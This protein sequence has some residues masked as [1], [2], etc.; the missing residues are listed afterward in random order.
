ME[1]KFEIPA[2]SF[3]SALEAAQNAGEPILG[4]TVSLQLK[5][6]G[7]ETIPVSLQVDENLLSQLNKG[8]SISLVLTNPNPESA[9]QQ[10]VSQIPTSMPPPPIEVAQVKLFK[11]HQRLKYFKKFMALF[12]TKL[13]FRVTISSSEENEIFESF[14]FLS[15]AH[16]MSA[17]HYVCS[18]NTLILTNQRKHL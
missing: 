4:A 15:Y 6:A 18:Q 7:M 3:K 17:W 2:E 16:F 12:N 8:Q 1:Q 9:V 11:D 5:Q 14:F 13:V 10:N